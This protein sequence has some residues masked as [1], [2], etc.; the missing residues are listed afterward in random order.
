MTTKP[1]IGVAFAKED[2]LEALRVAGAE[3]REL[4]PEHTPVPDAP[5]GLDAPDLLNGLDG[6]L[7]T[8]G[9]DVRPALYGALME[10]RTN[11]VDDA[12]DAFEV[13][14]V[15]AAL[16]RGLPILAICRGVQVLNI[17]AGGTLIQ[18]LPFARPDRL[19]HAVPTPR[20]AIAHDVA[21]VSGTQLAAIMAPR[22]SEGGR[23]AVNSRHH[24]AIDEVAPGFIVSASAPDGTIEAI[25][26]APG[27]SFCLGVQWHPENFWRTGEFARLFERFVSA[28]TARRG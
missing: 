21:V 25:E 7:L 18:D 26:S 12:R 3:V 16:A 14:L 20:T 17:V 4:S 1:V 10:H 15:R 13:P 5:D 8:G 24:Q 9:A 27:G 28:A 19:N 6:L 23:L 2:Y 22:L 11:S